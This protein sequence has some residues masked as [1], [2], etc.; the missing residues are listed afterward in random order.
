MDNSGIE[1]LI[2]HHRWL[3]NNGIVHDNIKNQLFMYGSIVH[4]DVAAVDL[5]VNATEKCISYKIFV[6]SELQQKIDKFNKL[7]DDQSFIG[8]WRFKRF[9]KKE[10][11][12]DFDSILNSFV[13]DYC[14]KGW[15]TNITTVDFNDYVEGYQSEIENVNYNIKDDIE[16]N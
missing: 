16:S 11:N 7:R 10:G 8:L 2:D 13:I 6:N 9:L 1:S 14:G 5:A 3:L 12:L 4:R 15:K